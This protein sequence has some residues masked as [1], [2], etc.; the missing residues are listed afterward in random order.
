[1]K[2]TFLIIIMISL[3]LMSCQKEKVNPSIKLTKTKLL[4]AFVNGTIFLSD[5]MWS[6]PFIY[7]NQFLSTKIIGKSGV[8]YI[9]LEFYH[10]DLKIGTFPLHYIHDSYS[11]GI[12]ASFCDLNE[13]TDP[14]SAPNYFSKS[15]MIQIT[16]ID[17]G[18][19]LGYHGVLI[20]LEANFFFLT[21]SIHG[22]NKQV[23]SGLILYHVY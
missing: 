23:E 11:S 7:N 17:T 19:F 9:G 18:T 1:M 15:G 2:N 14:E 8:K 4:K 10:E 13:M 16:Q 6:I 20:N 22:K 5:T 21:D 3:T 12:I